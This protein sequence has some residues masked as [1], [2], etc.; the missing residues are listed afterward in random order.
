MTYPSELIPNT[1]VTTTNDGTTVYTTASG[2]TVTLG[3]NNHEESDS[4]ISSSPRNTYA[5]S[6]SFSQIFNQRLQ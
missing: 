2:R 3:G 4:Y 6:L 5:V 1:S